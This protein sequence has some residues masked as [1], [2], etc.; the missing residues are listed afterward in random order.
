MDWRESN[1]EKITKESYL[2][3]EKPSVF[4]KDVF[5]NPKPLGYKG[6]MYSWFNL[7]KKAGIDM[8]PVR[9][10]G[11]HPVGSKNGV[12]LVKN[13]CRY[14]I[15]IHS[16][17][18]YFK[19]TCSVL[20]VDRMATEAMMGHSLRSFG[21]ESVY[22]YCIS[23]LEFLKEQYLKALPGLTFLVKLPS[24]KVENG[25]ARKKIEQLEKILVEKE[26]EL[27][28]LRKQLAEMQVVKQK[29]EACLTDDVIQ[30]LKELKKAKKK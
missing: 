9:I 6:V 14:N 23:N 4:S 8:K 17:R 21:I 26:L 29:V 24:I 28:T 10:K 13:A 30:L 20:G 15:R 11:Y 16:L 7:C 22:D 5:K 2:F 12:E 1:G 25:E 18:K 3:T 27:Q 19:T